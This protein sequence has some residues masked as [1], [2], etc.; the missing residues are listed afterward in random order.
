MSKGRGRLSKHQK[1]IALGAGLLAI[2]LIGAGAVFLYLWMNPAS[3]TPTY[4]Y[5]QLTRDVEEAPLET[6]QDLE[7]YVDTYGDQYGEINAQLA[8]TEVSS[9]G[10]NELDSVY[11]LIAYN[12]RIEEYREVNERLIQMQRAEEAGVDLDNNSLG[13]DSAYRDSL[14]HKTAE[15]LNTEGGTE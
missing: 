13:I 9:W 14:K 6:N 4:N 11:F 1:H 3:N 8:E 2:F 7:A 12:V 5:T 10:R 15:M